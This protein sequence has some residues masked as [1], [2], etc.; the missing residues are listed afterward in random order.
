[1][2]LN[3][4]YK[5]M[6]F[7]AFPFVVGISDSDNDTIFECLTAKRAWLDMDTK[8][9]EY[10]WLLRGHKN[11]PKK[12]IPFYLAEGPSPDT[13]LFMEGSD[14]APATVGKF[15]YSDYK[16]CAVMDSPYMGRQCVLWAKETTKDEL[17]QECLEVFEKKCGVGIPLYSKD[18][19]AESEV[20]NW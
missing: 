3:W 5:I 20:T 6:I 18:L 14:D 8:T 2:V 13:Y 17:P 1:M 4:L 7:E 9:A 19:C 15:Y 11:N 16:S 10:I 12:T